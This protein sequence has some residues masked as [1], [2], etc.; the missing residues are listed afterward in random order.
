MDTGT[1]ESEE[2]LLLAE[3]DRQ[4]LHPIYREISEKLGLNAA[5]ELY[6]MFKGQQ[7][8]FP[9]R[10]MDPRKVQKMIMQEYNGTNVRELAR[11]YGYSEK[12]VR[13]LIK[14]QNTTTNNDR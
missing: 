13:R 5:K 12:S 8:S 14:S 10:L 2:L 1:M 11:K 3:Q 4:M 6:Q 9:V 7:I